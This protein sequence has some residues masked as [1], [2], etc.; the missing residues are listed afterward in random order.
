MG[1]IE[2]LVEPSPRGGWVVKRRNRDAASFVY[3]SKAEADTAADE[4][5]DQ[6]GGG[7]VVER[8]ENGSEVARR[9]IP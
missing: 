5:V 8:D 2:R 3:G 1:E 9:Q 7:T 4:L 6:A